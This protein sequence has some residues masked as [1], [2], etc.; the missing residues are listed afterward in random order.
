MEVFPAPKA[1]G[2]P[3]ADSLSPEGGHRSPGRRVRWGVPMAKDLGNVGSK[4]QQRPRCRAR[5][6]RGS[7]LAALSQL[8]LP[9]R[10]VI[11]LAGLPLGSLCGRPWA[12]T[13][14]LV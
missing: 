4:E 5:C 1:G 6:R 14:V 3:W 10:S 12:G 11:L 13:W 7:A 2:Q 8:G 9:H